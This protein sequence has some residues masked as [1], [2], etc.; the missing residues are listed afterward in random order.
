M[1]WILKQQQILKQNNSNWDFPYG[2]KKL[3][4]QLTYKV[5][6]GAELKMGNNMV[7]VKRHGAACHQSMKVQ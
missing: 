6:V 3:L 5:N 4:S 7:V 2:C 1:V